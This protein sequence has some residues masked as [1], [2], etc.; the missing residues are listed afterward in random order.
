MHCHLSLLEYVFNDATGQS[1]ISGDASEINRRLRVDRSNRENSKGQ[2]L[3]SKK[4]NRIQTPQ[5]LIFVMK[6]NK[7]YINVPGFKLKVNKNLEILIDLVCFCV[8]CNVSKECVESGC[9]NLT[10]GSPTNYRGNR[11]IG[12]RVWRYKE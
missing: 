7:K 8:C 11:Q 2:I 5:N 1:V 10:N 12:E 9:K 4:V 6:G 3:S